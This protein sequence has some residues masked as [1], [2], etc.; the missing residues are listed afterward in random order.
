LRTAGLW[1]QKLEVAGLSHRLE[2]VEYVVDERQIRGGSP[3][4]IHP[5]PFF[6]DDG[7]GPGRSPQLVNDTLL[8]ALVKS[9]HPGVGQLWFGGTQARPQVKAI[10][11][12]VA[13]ESGAVVSVQQI[14]DLGVR[15]DSGFR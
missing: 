5:R 9:L 10:D 4:E 3:G 15:L 12:R 7:A 13:D 8:L 14:N 6:A 11:A 2:I 1:Q